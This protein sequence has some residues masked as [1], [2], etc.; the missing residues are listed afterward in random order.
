M[1]ARRAMRLALAYPR[2]CLVLYCLLCWLP[3]FFTLPPSDRDESRFAQATKQM[4][5]TNDFVRIREGTQARNKKPVGIYWLQAPFAAA[6]GREHI[7]AYRIPSLLGA[8]AAVQLTYALGQRIASQPAALLAAAMLGGAVLL[9]VEA[10]IAKTDAVLLAATTAAM[11][12]L[13]RAYLDP[14]GVTPRLAAGFWLAMAAGVLVKGPV[15]PMVAALAAVSLA[16]WD[17]RAGWMRALRPGWGAARMLLAVLPWFVAIGIVTRGQFF[18]EAVGGDLG[19][20]LAGGAESHWGPPGLYLLMLPLLL[21]PG[22]ALVLPGVLTAWRDRANPVSRALLAWVVP[23][24]IVFE[25]VPTKLPHYP[26]PLYP[27]L[28]LL[29]AR[30]VTDWGAERRG[31][32]RFIARVNLGLA[33]DAV[34]LL[35]LAAVGLPVS[36]DMSP[37]ASLWLGAPGAAAA[38]LAAGLLWRR[39]VA[40]A[41]VA[42][43]LLYGA[44]LGLELP[45]LGALWLSPR[46]A[47]VA[48][49][50]AAKPGVLGAVGYAEPSL[51]FLAG[52]D[53]VFLPGAAAGA[54]ALALGQVDRLL[55]SDRDLA[56]FRSEAAHLGLDAHDIAMIR[57]YN[58]SRGRWTELTV[59]VR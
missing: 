58:Y 44:V 24:W 52:T 43:P 38:V 47:E 28:C 1:L 16:L 48:A 12:V 21:F 4:L 2:L 36:L 10:H 55:V 31:A 59:F 27:A 13:I 57:G 7:W 49:G 41:L 9:T 17:R 46:A 56:A 40:A 45:R 42:M 30:W 34:L 20:K 35:A 39:G 50:A 51:R 19:G 29:G 8:L 5:E 23:A 6:L 37:W 53:T 26:L 25:L 18:R 33:L 32:L 11:L 14:G 22:S 3:G 54:R 15:T